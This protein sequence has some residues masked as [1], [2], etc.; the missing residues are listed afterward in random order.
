M[1]GTAGRD[2]PLLLPHC[3]LKGGLMIGW[4]KRRLS[5]WLGRYQQREIERLYAELV[6]RKADALRSNG[7]KPIRLSPDQH[8]LLN[9]PAKRSIP[10]CSA[11]SICS[12]TQNN[13]RRKT[14]VTN[15]TRFTRRL[16]FLT[17]RARGNRRLARRRQERFAT[18]DVAGPYAL[19]VHRAVHPPSTAN[20]HPVV[21]LEASDARY[22]AAP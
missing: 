15:C 1:S 5:A 14:E 11:S 2:A 12:P 21:K 10:K 18:R 6:Q 9:E 13:V 4:F 17:I 7:G 3:G 20:I 22:S 8:R 16:D 19:L